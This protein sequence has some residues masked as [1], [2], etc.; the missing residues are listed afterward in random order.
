MGNCAFILAA[1]RTSEESIGHGLDWQGLQAMQEL[2]GFLWGAY[3][4]N[5]VVHLPDVDLIHQQ[6]LAGAFGSLE[7]CPNLFEPFFS[8]EEG[9]QGEGV[10]HMWL[11]HVV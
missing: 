8:V 5:D 11:L 6:G 4:G 7:Q 3:L 9:Q 1:A 2:L 10:E